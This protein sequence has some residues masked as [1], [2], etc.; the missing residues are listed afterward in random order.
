M[1]TP[2]RGDVG[3][4]VSLR[5]PGVPGA[6]ELMSQPEHGVAVSSGDKGFGGRT[7]VGVPFPSGGLAEPFANRL[8]A[9][10]NVGPQLVRAGGAGAGMASSAASLGDVNQ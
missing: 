9:G 1:D 7:E 5:R 6:G 2:E 4:G 3:S 10:R 8:D